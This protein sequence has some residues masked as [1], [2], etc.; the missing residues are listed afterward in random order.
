[1][2]LRTTIA[3]VAFAL[4]SWV[5]IPPAQQAWARLLVSL[6]PDR[7][8]SVACEGNPVYV[9][10]FPGGRAHFSGRMRFMITPL[11]M[12]FNV[13]AAMIPFVVTRPSLGANLVRVVAVVLLVCV[14]NGGR[15]LLMDTLHGRDLP[16]WA[17]HEVP[18]W[19]LAFAC[20]GGAFGLCAHE[21]RLIRS[22]HID[23]PA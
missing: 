9:R 11:C 12:M 16:Q 17:A 15:L 13:S 3:A 8:H 6:S 7:E 23:R 18:L 14:L 20:I 1:M 2:I 10:T 5:P 22:T 21:L 19:V 4:F